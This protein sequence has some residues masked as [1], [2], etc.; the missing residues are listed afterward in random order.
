[1]GQ[2]LVAMY[3]LLSGSGRPK[4]PRTT[5]ATDKDMRAEGLKQEA[6]AN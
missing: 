6:A 3:E 1:M 4:T 2:R 5:D